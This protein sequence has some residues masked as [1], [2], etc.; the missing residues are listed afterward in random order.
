MNTASLTKAGIGVA[1]A[2][3]VAKFAPNQAVKA[4]AFGVAGVIVGLQVP[5]VRDALRA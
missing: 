4:A 3:A 1:I 5:Y 2:L